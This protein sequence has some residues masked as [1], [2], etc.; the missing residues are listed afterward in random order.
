[1]DD[2]T[3]VKVDQKQIPGQTF[4]VEEKLLDVPNKHQFVQLCKFE[5]KL[6]FG[7]QFVRV[8]RRVRLSQQHQL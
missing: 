5:K 1:M 6:L 7:K 8:A 2:E 4:Y 3:Y